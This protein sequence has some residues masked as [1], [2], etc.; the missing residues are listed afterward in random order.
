MTEHVYG[1]QVNS[2]L[3]RNILV[4][5]VTVSQQFAEEQEDMLPTSFILGM[6]SALGQAAVAHM[7]QNPT[8]EIE[9]L[10][11]LVAIALT[12]LANLRSAL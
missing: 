11:T 6:Q 2:L 8:Q 9:D 12:R 5:C 3:E 1:I 10:T 4:E 7:N